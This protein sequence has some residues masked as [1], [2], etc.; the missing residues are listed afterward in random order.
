M[1]KHSSF[2]RAIATAFFVLVASMLATVAYGQEKIPITVAMPTV[3]M[4][5]HTSYYSSIP[6]QVFWPKEGLDVNVVY[7]PGANAAAGA[8]D[9]GKAQVSF[10]ANSALFS[11]LQ[12]HPET[13][14]MGYYTFIQHFQS[15]P[16]VLP[17]SP[18][19]TIADLKGKTIGLQALGNSQVQTT[20]ALL[21]LAGVEPDSVKFVATGEG[22]AA[23]RALKTGR[24]D[25]L[26]LYDALYA[27]VEANGTELR[28]LKSE[29]VTA[30]TV[31]FQSSV[32]VKR[33]YFE[34]HKDALIRLGRGV[35]KATLFAKTNPKAAVCIHW[36]VYPGTKPKGVSEAE[37]MR[38][39]L[40]PLNRRQT[41]VEKVDGLW[42][43]ATREQVKGYM[44][45]LVAGG[46]L[47]NPIPVDAVWDPSLLEAI[48]NFDKDAVREL[49]KNWPS[50]VSEDS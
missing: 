46:V 25:A 19:Q 47:K 36:Q 49:A 14:I 44:E 13:N 38:R 33:D 15:M 34:N 18:L 16:E 21:E 43:G 50:C 12:A 1:Y 41:N 39:S 42:G 5:P 22:A 3:L 32:F 2:V 35:A 27:I 23:A 11:L 26:A 30:E 8:L 4:Q 45:F 7:L 48:N 40:A 24:V 37:A 20:R 10:A 6:M 17:E 9:A 28:P 31:G 29:S